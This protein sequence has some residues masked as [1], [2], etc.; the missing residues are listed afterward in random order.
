LEHNAMAVSMNEDDKRVECALVGR[1]S[2]VIG[3]GV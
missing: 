2:L 3:F 1:R